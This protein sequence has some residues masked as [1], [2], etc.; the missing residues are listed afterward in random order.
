M[1]NDYAI[2]MM[3]IITMIM[4][5]ILISQWNCSHIRDLM[6][7]GRNCAHFIKRGW[8]AVW[9]SNPRCLPDCQSTSIVRVTLIFSHVQCVRREGYA[10]TLYCID[11]SGD[12]KDR[13]YYKILSQTIIGDENTLIR[14]GAFNDSFFEK[15]STAYISS[16]KMSESLRLTWASVNQ[17]PSVLR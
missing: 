9:G 10:H 6:N 11:K 5:I 17:Y 8:G 12:K 16:F 7:Q 3:T 4:M 13:V 14:K 15:I 2:T 1:D